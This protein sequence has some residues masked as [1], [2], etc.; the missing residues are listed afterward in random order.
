MNKYTNLYNTTEYTFLDSIIRVDDLVRLSKEHGL[1]AVALT[2]H[3]NLFGL[4]AFLKSCQKYDIK[5]II[6]VDLD[7]DE[8]RFILLAK[9]YKGFQKINSLILKKSKNVIININEIIDENVFI[10]DH[11]KLGYY[12]KT[13][14]M[15]LIDSDSYYVNSYDTSIKNG[16]ITKTN[17]L[18]YLKDNDTLNIVQKLSNNTENKFTNDYFDNSVT[19]SIIIDRINF[20]IDN[21]NFKLPSKKL[22]LADFNNNNEED[23]EKML[24]KLLNEGL[25]RISHELPKNKDLWRARLA[26]EFETIKSLGFINYFLIIQ[27]LVNWAK[28]NNI[29]IGPG[30]GSA[31]GSFISYLLNIT[32][33]NPLKYDLL[34]ERFLN[35]QRVSWPDIDIDIQDDRRMEVF[36]YLKNKYGNENVALISTFQTLGAKMA[37]RDVGRVLGISL[38]TINAIS[39]TLSASETLTEAMQGNVKFK[40]AIEQYP[41]LLE[42]ALK[43]EGLPRQQSYHP[44]GLIISK[45]PIISYA[46]A[47]LTND[48]SYQQVQ[49]TMDYTEQF[50]LLKIDLLGLKTLTEVQN[51]EYFI[52]EKEWFDNLLVNDPAKMVLNDQLTFLRLNL[53]YTEGIFQLESPG[54]KKTIATVQLNSFDDLYAIISLFRPGPLKYIKN[55]AQNKQDTDLIEKIH[56]VYDEILRPTFG[57]MV[58]QEQI[59]LIAQKVA[60]MSFVEADFLRRA[61]SKKHEDEIKQYKDKF[62][63]GALDNGLEISQIKKIYKNIEQFAEYGFNKSHAVSYAYLTMK[64]AYYKTY[65]P[66]IFYSALI[67]NSRGAQDKIGK[68][69]EEIKKQNYIVNSPNILHSLNA[70]LIK[71]NQIYLPFDLIKGFGNDG[72]SKIMSSINELGPF[73]NNLNET[74]LR[75]RFAGLTENAL[76]L[77]V[78]ANVFRDFGHMKFIENAV[79]NLLECF[80]LV[81]NINNWPEAREKLNKSGY[82]S[83]VHDEIERDINYE[84]TNEISLLGTCYNA[85]PTIEYEKQFKYKLSTIPNTITTEIAVQIIRKTILPGKSFFVIEVSDSTMSHAFFISNKNQN[86]WSPVNVGDIVK[87]KISNNRGKLRLLEFGII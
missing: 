22:N 68:Y 8:Y 17:K 38:V 40:L 56:P 59:M 61:I 87:I 10:I 69:V 36:E 63:R 82:L 76:D 25:T 5:P 15:D 28:N 78:R 42:H 31:A 79:K 53:G 46:P 18:L 21:C 86:L 1:N 20:I 48:G 45:Q 54:M 84:S 37:I 6:G 70:C 43:I 47:S 33:I 65:Y 12:A 27:D 16:I 58:Y 26:Y 19:D 29:A 44:A 71:N 7:V 49:L 34:F 64:M 50:G 3:N 41:E 85:H 73:T 62:V 32:S 23:N 14:K 72:V 80:K 67:S 60:G 4:G 83:M 13:G 9:N 81:S 52:P 39:K 24:I 11:P 66:L 55:Y 74:I 51:M 2:D 35:P 30:R 75:L 57:I 77:L